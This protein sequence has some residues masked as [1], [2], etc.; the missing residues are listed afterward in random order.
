MKDVYMNFIK[1][2]LKTRT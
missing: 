1:A 2:C